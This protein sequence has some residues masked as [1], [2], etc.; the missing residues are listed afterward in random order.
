MTSFNKRSYNQVEK[1]RVTALILAGGES[2]RFNGVDKGLLAFNGKPMVQS[3]LARVAPQ[4]QTV[5]ISCNRNKNQYRDILQQFYTTATPPPTSQ[6]FYDDQRSPLRGPLAGIYR[7]LQQCTSPYVF[8]CPCDTPTLPVDIVQKLAA[9]LLNASAD[10][11]YPVD[12]H[13]RHHLAILVKAPIALAA[14]EKLSVALEQ[15]DSTN[16]NASHKSIGSIK[17]WLHSLNSTQLT[18][19]D[20]F[21]DFLNINNAEQ[22]SAAEQDL[23]H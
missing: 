6:C 22:L 7:Y 11:S 14:L 8:I 13:G 5:A 1:Q 3:V 12:P 17:S 16:K 21:D 23:R 18:F 10:A 20:T 4:V 15:N 9:A 19:N 2:R